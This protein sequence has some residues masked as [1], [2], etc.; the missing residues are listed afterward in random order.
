M[1]LFRT[2]AR[3]M[4]D[5][6]LVPRRDAA[7]ASGPVPG[8]AARLAGLS[9]IAVVL[10]AGCAQQATWDG[11]YRADRGGGAR[12]CLASPVSPQ[13]GQAVVEQMQVSDEGGWCGINAARGGV[14]FDSYLMVTRP[15]HGTI[16]AHHVGITTRIDYTPDAGYV[17]NDAFALRMIPGNAVIQ[18]SVAVSQ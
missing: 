1:T 7:L 11:I 13:D 18:G 17:G 14:A 6:G 15:S 16:F 4:A 2:S 5:S 3:G 12:I 10:L 8:L 9:L